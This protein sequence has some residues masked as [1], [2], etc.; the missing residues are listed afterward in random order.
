MSL[1]LMSFCPA[2]DEELFE[3]NPEEYI[4]RDIEGS[5]RSHSGLVS[6]TACSVVIFDC[7]HHALHIH[8][9]LLLYIIIEVI[10]VLQ[11]CFTFRFMNLKQLLV[12]LTLS[13]GSGLGVPLVEFMYLVFTSLTGESYHRWLRSLLLCLCGDFRMLINSVMCWWWVGCFKL[14]NIEWIPSY[15]HHNYALWLC[16]A[17]SKSAFPLKMNSDKK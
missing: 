5:G 12:D 17:S 6:F 8:S 1:C 14:H 4:R 13:P 16:T 3:D 7:K 10:F 9:F 11:F 15:V 2:A